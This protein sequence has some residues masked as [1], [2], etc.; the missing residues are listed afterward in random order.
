MM[1]LSGHN[2][3]ISRGAPVLGIKN[4]ETEMKNVIDSPVSKVDRA[5]GRNS[6]LE[7]ILAKK[8]KSNES[9]TEKNRTH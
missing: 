9:K 4:T 7:D 2:P 5:K 3:I 6:E 8:P 1:D